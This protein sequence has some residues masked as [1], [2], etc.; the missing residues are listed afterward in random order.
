MGISSERGA[1]PLPS[2]ILMRH[3]TNYLFSVAVIFWKCVIKIPASGWSRLATT[4]PCFRWPG[5]QKRW[6]LFLHIAFTENWRSG[7]AIVLFAQTIIFAFTH[8]VQ[9]FPFIPPMSLLGTTVINN[10]V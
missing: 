2:Q 3:K 6:S 5:K 4:E 8:H 9:K 10:I 7:R 1:A